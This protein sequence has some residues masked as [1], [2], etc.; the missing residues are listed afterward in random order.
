MDIKKIGENP[1]KE[2][3]IETTGND[4]TLN[5]LEESFPILFGLKKEKIIGEKNILVT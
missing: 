3:K 1:K 4:P 2:S 5:S